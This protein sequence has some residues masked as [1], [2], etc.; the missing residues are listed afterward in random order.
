M[1]LSLVYDE[2]TRDAGSQPTAQ[3]L[4]D[5]IDGFWRAYD[6]EPLRGPHTA[7]DRAMDGFRETARD[8]CKTYAHSHVVSDRM[9]EQH[10]QELADAGDTAGAAWVVCFQ[11]D[12]LALRTEAYRQRLASLVKAMVSYRKQQ[13]TEAFAHKGLPSDIHSIIHGMAA[14][15]ANPF[16]LSR[17]CSAPST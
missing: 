17:L 6:A 8:A 9:L 5:A 15:R 11:N 10:R 16:V 12:D 14:A 3:A 7:Y 1:D 4:G 13:K 2:L